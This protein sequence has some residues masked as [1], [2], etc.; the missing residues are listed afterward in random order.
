MPDEKPPAAPPTEG[1]G[2]NSGAGTGTGGSP[3]AGAPPPPTA[4]VFTSEQEAHIGALLKAERE[5]ERDAAQK[6]TQ[7]E[8]QQAQERTAQEQGQFKEVAEQRAT[9]I[10]ELETANATLTRQLL[11]A[12]HGRDLPAALQAVVQGDTEDVIKAHIAE[13]RK[14]VAPPTAPET[15]AGKG[16]RPSTPPPTLPGAGAQAGAGAAKPTAPYS[17]TQPG[18]IPW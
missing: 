2:T 7:R 1:P 17:F 14:L 15:E 11:I 16:T 8:Q 12:Q 5:K 6:R 18:D 9:R 13:L 10:T 4:V 3:V